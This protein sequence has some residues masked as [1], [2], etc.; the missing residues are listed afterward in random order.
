M[1]RFLLPF[2]L[3]GLSGCTNPANSELKTARQ[4]SDQ[5]KYDLAEEHY[6]RVI[7]RDPGS[8]I[9][10]QAIREV[11]QI[12]QFQKKNY[13]KA[14][15]FYKLLILSSDDVEERVQ[16]QK[17]IASIYFS[18]IQDYKNAIIEYN[19][20]LSFETIDYDKSQVYLSL[21]RANFYLN[22]FF[23]ADSEVNEVLNIK[24]T[25]EQKFEAILIKSNIALSQKAYKEAI[26]FL[27]LLLLDYNQRAIDANVPINLAVCFEE[28]GDY[29]AAI[30]TLNKFIKN[31]QNK[32]DFFEL[33]IKKLKERQKNQPG[34]HGLK[35]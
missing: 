10:V 34:A 6:F 31:Y 3:A 28:L 12:E 24:S 32:R 8:L 33:R 26:D 11:I 15:E 17:S 23:Q 30:G 20:L 19:K 2:A 29:S 5:K 7:S 13:L 9:A 4:F 35:K 16:A 25:E 27:K 22:N 1:I 18:N 14:I 21:A